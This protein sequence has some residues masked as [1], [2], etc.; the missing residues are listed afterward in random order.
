MCSHVSGRC[1]RGSASLIDD[2]SYMEDAMLRLWGRSVDM[3]MF[4]ISIGPTSSFVLHTYCLRTIDEW[5][6]I[7]SIQVSCNVH[8]PNSSRRLF[9][10]EAEECMMSV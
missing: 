7:G 10:D 6:Q 8:A 9:N 3:S 2:A 1:V 4:I 5:Q